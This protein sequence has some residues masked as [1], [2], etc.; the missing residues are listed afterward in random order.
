MCTS[1]STI[2]TRAIAASNALT[3]AILPVECRQMA[4]GERK[5]HTPGKPV[6][7]PLAKPRELQ[8]TVDSTKAE[9][10]AVDVSGVGA[11]EDVD[12]GRF[13]PIA[14]L[15]HGGMGVVLVAL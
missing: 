12:L 2:K 14:M 15:G 6:S 3:G 13:L 10:T 8:T 4:E 1:S 7:G 9:G 11:F 5:P